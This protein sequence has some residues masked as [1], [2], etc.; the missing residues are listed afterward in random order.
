MNFL[1]CTTSDINVIIDIFLAPYIKETGPATCM[2]CL[3]CHSISFLVA[4]MPLFCALA[5][6]GLKSG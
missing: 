6:V 2:K 1:V 4:L 5:Q 3:L